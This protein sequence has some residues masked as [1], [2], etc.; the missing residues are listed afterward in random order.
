MADDSGE[1]H[2]FQPDP[3]GIIPLD[4]F[5]VPASL[6]RRVRSGRFKITVDTCFE[7]VMR[8]CSLARSED[9]GSWM[10]EQLLGAYC[11]LHD[12][13]AAHSLEAWRD[14]RLVGGVYGVHLGGAFFGESMFSRPK[15]G[16]TDASKV[17]LVHLVE[18]LQA[19]GFSLLDT[20][21]VNEHL[22]QFGCVEIPG[23][24]YAELLRIALGES[25][26]F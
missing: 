18:R 20:Q 15:I 9:N 25:I 11:D 26:E 21:Y 5:R 16:G 4:R 3:R 13:G 1:V 23:E 2:W 24:S 19:R 12:R 7:E 10:T 22:R 6:S 14:G 17:C 8:E